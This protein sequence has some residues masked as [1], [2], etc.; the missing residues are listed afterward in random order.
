MD[1]NFLRVFA[2]KKRVNYTRKSRS[3]L[4]RILA[5]AMLFSHKLQRHLVA[6]LALYV[7]RKERLLFMVIM[8]WFWCVHYIACGQSHYGDTDEDANH[9]YCMIEYESAQQP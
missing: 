6:A 8:H 5:I 4:C 2:S 9:S 1:R 3:E 7:Y